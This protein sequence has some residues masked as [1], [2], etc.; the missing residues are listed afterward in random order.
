MKRI[1]FCLAIIFAACNNNEQQQQT[2]TD[3]AKTGIDTVPGGVRSEEVPPP[4]S[5]PPPSLSKI[6]SNE[7]FKDVTVERN[8]EHQFLITG[9]ARVFEANISW[10]VEDGHEELKK[11][12][13]M[14]DAGAPA[15][16][17]FKFNI[18]VQKKRQHSTLTLI[19]FESSARDGNREHELPL[20][21]Y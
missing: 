5:P 7:R 16:G 8:G 13:Q 14:T 12:F 6:Y 19:L 17:N 2:T 15:W 21:L 18:D 4:L 10:V 20:R 3:S 1:F 11:G 9:K